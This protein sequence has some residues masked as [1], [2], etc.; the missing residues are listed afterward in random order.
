MA[1]C[2]EVETAG[3][4]QE[5][6]RGRLLRDEEGSESERGVRYLGGMVCTRSL[7]VVGVRECQC[8]ATTIACPKDKV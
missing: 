8:S 3:R 5:G 7:D 2:Y 4:G 1:D 6:C